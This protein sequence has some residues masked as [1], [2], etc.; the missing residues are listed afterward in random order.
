MIV[1]ATNAPGQPGV[2]DSVVLGTVHMHIKKGVA[3]DI[4]DLVVTS[5]TE[6]E[7]SNAKTELI[8]LMGMATQGGHIDTAERT[9]A[10]LYAKELVA[11]VSELDK[12]NRMPKVVVSSDQLGRI[13]L[14]KKGLSPSEAVPISSR[15]NELEDTVKRLC[16]SFEKFKSENKAQDRI[17][18][19]IL[20]DARQEPDPN[21]GKVK[22]LLQLQLW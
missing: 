14:G 1:M 11:M 6:D 7:I 15:M 13:P 20:L 17:L 8:E 5:F 22:L 2:I 10:S 19:L 18:L 12:D 16:E 21:M 9:A 3:S 4:V